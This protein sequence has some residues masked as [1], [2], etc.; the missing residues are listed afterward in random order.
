MG[1]DVVLLGF[2][3]A[4][5]LGS[6]WRIEAGASGHGSLQFISQLL[7][8]LLRQVGDHLAGEN[9]CC[10]QVALELLKLLFELRVFVVANIL[11]SNGKHRELGVF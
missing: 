1:L 6:R 5:S 7:D 11:H 10:G 8:P 9:L 2:F 3:E 4:G